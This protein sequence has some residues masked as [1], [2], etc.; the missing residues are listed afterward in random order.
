MEYHL[1]TSA[2]QR[3]EDYKQL[4]KEPH[5]YFK[6]LT[7][8]G[9]K[10]TFFHKEHFLEV[11]FEDDSIVSGCYLVNREIMTIDYIKSKFKS[12]KIT[13]IDGAMEFCRVVDK[14]KEL[15]SRETSI[16][17]TSIRIEKQITEIYNIYLHL[18]GTITYKS[19]NPGGE[20]KYETFD[21]FKASY[22]GKGKDVGEYEPFPDHYTLD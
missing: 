6:F 7:K 17:D 1:A 21:E 4:T 10:Y 9:D 8:V 2:N 13:H 22:L 19:S 5:P 15:E 14:V 18:D 12:F 11:E 16:G 20:W 3:I